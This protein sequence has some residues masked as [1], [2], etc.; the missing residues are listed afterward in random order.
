MGG[1]VLV[2]DDDPAFRALAVRLL[3]DSGLNVVGEVG[4]AAEALS[5]A[6]ALRPD[7]ALID[8]WLPDRDGVELARDLVGPPWRLRVVLT[9]GDADAARLVGT[10]PNDDFPFALKEDLPNAALDRLLAVG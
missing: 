8:V 9:S 10:D 5:A 6:E 1:S 3:V 4:T 7:A 2:V